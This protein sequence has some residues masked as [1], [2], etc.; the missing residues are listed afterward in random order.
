MP[1]TLRDLLIQAEMRPLDADVF[2]RLGGAYLRR[3]RLRKAWDAYRRAYV[4]DPRD[5]FTFLYVGN[6]CFA[7]GRYEIM[8]KWFRRA[9]RLIPRLAVAY[10]CMG[11]VFRHLGWNAQAEFAYRYAVRV[12]PDDVQAREMLAEWYEFRASLN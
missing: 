1:M 6:L 5:P 11:H 8:L 10:W 9:R 4:L 7:R 2:Q 12:A 3:R